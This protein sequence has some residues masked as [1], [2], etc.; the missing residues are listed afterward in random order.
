MLPQEAAESLFQSLA[1][2]WWI[3]IIFLPYKI[4]CCAYYGHGVVPRK[5]VIPYLS[6]VVSTTQ[7]G[8]AHE[9]L[10][11]SNINIEPGFRFL[12]DYVHA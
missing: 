10:G 11:L 8:L 1:Q 7:A 5:A 3:I 12:A 6:D 2:S 9:I 4:P